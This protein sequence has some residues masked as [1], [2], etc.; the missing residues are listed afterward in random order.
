MQGELVA[1]AGT[2]TTHN[3]LQLT[4]IPADFPTAARNLGVHV[5]QVFLD[6]AIN[7]GGIAFVRVQR[8]DG[9]GTHRQQLIGFRHGIRIREPPRVL[10]R[11]TLLQRGRPLLRLLHQTLQMLI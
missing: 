11:Q 7:A 6:L 4:L 10:N 3:L 2:F 5:A 8:L 1:I 9:T